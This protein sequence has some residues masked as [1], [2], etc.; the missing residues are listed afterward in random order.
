MKNN[1]YL[2]LSWLLLAEQAN[3]DWF[4]RARRCVAHLPQSGRE[5]PCF[6]LSFTFGWLLIGW[7]ITRHYL[8][9]PTTDSASLVGNQ[10][11][12]RSSRHL[13][14]LIYQPSFSWT[15]SFPSPWQWAYWTS[16]TEPSLLW[17]IQHARPRRQNR[18]LSTFLWFKSQT[19]SGWSRSTHTWP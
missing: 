3:L 7:L 13:C 6:P 14:G 18:V 4:T 12:S 9:N 1:I 2:Q 8:G 10:I 15:Q 11:S 16:N 5:C 19:W 17:S